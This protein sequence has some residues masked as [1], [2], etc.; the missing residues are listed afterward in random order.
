MRLPL[1]RWVVAVAVL[2][3]NQIHQDRRGGAAAGAAAAGEAGG[4]EVGAGRGG[5]GLKQPQYDR[6]NFAPNNTIRYEVNG[7]T[8]GFGDCGGGT[9]RGG[10]GDTPVQVFYLCDNVIVS[11]ASVS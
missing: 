6:S 7:H 1:L 11:S 8:V 9:H 10:G 2:L 4:G 5:G 3:H